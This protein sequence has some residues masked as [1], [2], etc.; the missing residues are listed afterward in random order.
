MADKSGQGNEGTIH[1]AEPAT[2]R[3]G[4]ERSAMKFKGSGAWIEAKNKVGEKLT[5]LITVSAWV[6]KQA[7]TTT[8]AGS[9]AVDRQ[10]TRSITSA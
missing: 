5:Q 6:K 8:G 9:S 1:G 10:S 7:P 4:K 3:H 2:D